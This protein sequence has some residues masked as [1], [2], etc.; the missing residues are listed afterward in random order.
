MRSKSLASP[1]ALIASMALHAP[2]S[3]SRNVPTATAKS[4]AV[5]VWLIVRPRKVATGSCGTRA[6]VG[7]FTDRP[8]ALAPSRE[9]F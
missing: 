6:S 4:P 9:R 7:T 1:T 2:K 8:D 5:I 3:A